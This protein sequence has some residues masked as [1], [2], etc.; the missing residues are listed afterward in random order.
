[1][2]Q[3]A[4][5]LELGGRILNF[6]DT[7]IAPLKA[8]GFSNTALD[9]TLATMGGWAPIGTRVRWPYSS[10]P[11]E[12]AQDLAPGPGRCCPSCSASRATCHSRLG[13]STVNSMKIGDGRPIIAVAEHAFAN[14]QVLVEHFTQA[15][16]RFVEVDDPGKLGPATEGASGLVVTLQPLRKA[17]I[18]ALSASVKVIGRA[19]VGLDT[20]DLVAAA[21]AGV[22]VVNQPAYGTHEVASHAVALFLALQRRICTQDAYVRNGWSG[23]LG[24]SPMLPLDE[25]VVGIVGCGRIGY[26]TATLLLPL[27]AQVIVYDPGDP[28]IPDG[29]ARVAELKELLGRCHAVSL[30]LPLTPDSAGMVDAGFL[31][32]MTPGA[33]LINV[34]RGGVVDEGAVVAALGSGQ[35]GGAALDVFAVE[36]LPADSPLLSANNTVFSPHSASY[37][38]RSGWRLANWT[39]GDTLEWALSGRVTYGNIVVRGGR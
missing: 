12:V 17:H 10:V 37:S 21:A 32:A 39:I 28:P 1:M 24:L 4:A 5:A 8:Q 18:E 31:A 22:T 16:L 36:P 27:V 14:R 11:G 3:P 34:S 15:E 33:L 7:Y 2:G 13:S 35:L 6:F 20:I 19:G 29:V 23:H 38:E 9:K 26:A 30:H 25:M